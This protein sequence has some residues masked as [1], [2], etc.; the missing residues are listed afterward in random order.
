MGQQPA[1]FV[2]DGFVPD[3]APPPAAA[4][5]PAAAEGYWEH[6]SGA[7]IPQSAVNPE[8]SKRITHE[9]GWQWRPP[10]W[11][12]GRD[13]TSRRADVDIASGVPFLDTLSPE[14]LLGGVAAVRAIGGAVA[15]NQLGAA[16]RAL[17]GLQET[18]RH[19]TPIA[20]YEITRHV[21]ERVGVPTPIAVIL[22]T[23][24]SGYQRGRGAA[25]A[26]PGPAPAP[27]PVPPA[28]T[29]PRPVG[30]S[31]AWTPGVLPRAPAPVGEPTSVSGRPAAGVALPASAPG[32]PT[33][34]AGPTSPQSVPTPPPPSGS[35]FGWSPQRIRNEVGLAARRMNVTL[36]EPQAKAAEDLVAA[37]RMPTAAVAEAAPVKVAA[38]PEVT[39]PPA[40]KPKVLAAEMKEYSR[41]RKL[42][43]SHMEAVEVLQAQR[44]LAR[45]LGTPTSEAVR[46]T[47]VERNLSGE[48]PE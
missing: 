26:E 39:P 4:A 8:T 16:Q 3:T 2:P 23:G 24:I 13:P 17:A 41:L 22:A 48:W 46:Q 40:A 10:G 25:P 18:L 47:I 20:K 15:S 36:T 27:E 37:G 1:G 43:K 5:P 33:P 19:A 28:P 45:R 38:A 14:A 32:A 12:L 11:A 35:G 21:L 42:G 9:S 31:T 30:T 44:E 6:S 7:R 29:P 34:P